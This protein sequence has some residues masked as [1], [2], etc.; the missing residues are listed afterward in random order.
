MWGSSAD[1]QFGAIVVEK[2]EKQFFPKLSAAGKAHYEEEMQLCAYE[3]ARADGTLAMSEAAM[4]QVDVAARFAANPTLAATPLPRA[5]FD[6]A[7]AQSPLEKAI[8][9]DTR[10]GHADI[11]LG[12][13]YRGVVKSLQGKQ[14]ADLVDSEKKWLAGVAQ[15]CHANA[16]LNA[17]ERNCVVVEFENRFTDLD[18]CEDAEEDQ[19][20]AECLTE[21]AAAHGQEA[22]GESERTNRASFDCEKPR[23]ALEIVICG[24]LVGTGGHCRCTDLSEI[25]RNPVSGRASQTNRKSTRMAQ[26]RTKHLPDGCCG[27][28][29]RNP[30]SLMHKDGIR[31]AEYAAAGVRSKARI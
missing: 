26:L 10:L 30:H 27:R 3:Y 1:T 22:N 18:S 29:S 8:C 15:D 20:L 9:S 12:R 19:G 5:S 13:V 31:H 25:A 23:D 28:Y 21:S 11:V 6:C 24:C 17:A 4:C 7:R 16:P 2:C 14:A